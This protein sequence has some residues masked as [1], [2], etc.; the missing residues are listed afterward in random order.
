MCNQ[1]SKTYFITLEV[2]VQ[3]T[4]SVTAQTIE[5]AMAAA[6]AQIGS[7]GVESYHMNYDVEDQARVTQ[8]E[9]V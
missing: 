9:E 3:V 2:P 4:C 8:V 5:D 6:R 7:D 1:Y